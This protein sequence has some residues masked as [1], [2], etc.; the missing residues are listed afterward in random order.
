MMLLEDDDVMKKFII[1]KKGPANFPPRLTQ[2]LLRLSETV[3]GKLY[4]VGGLVRDGLTG[5]IS[6]DIDLAVP[7][8]AVNLAR[9][10]AHEL[11]ATFVLLDEDE[12]VARVVWQEFEIDLADFHDN[13]STINQD[14]S[15]RDFTINAL[16]VNLAHCLADQCELIDPCGGLADL[17]SGSIRVVAKDSF[18]ADPLRLLRAFRF[19][20]TLDFSLESKTLAA[21]SDMAELIT[22]PSPERI[23]Y[24]LEQIMLTERAAITFA[25][26]A[27]CG[28]LRHIFPELSQGKGMA[29]PASHHLDVFF[30]NMAALD[31][32]EKLQIAPDRFFPEKLTSRIISYLEK[33]Q[34]R[35]RL[36][37]AALFHDLGKPACH[38]IRRERITFY[39][40]DQVGADEFIKIAG[41]LR[42]SRADI[43]NI[44]LLIRLH[45]WP[46]HLNNARKKNGLTSRAC[47]RLFKAIGP[48]L[49]GLFLLTMADSLAGQGPGRP[50]DM[51]KEL[52]DLYSEIDRICR[53]QIKP[54]L[55]APRLVNGRDLIALG[56]QPGPI[57]KKILA[58]LEQAQV[59]G[60]I[61][62]RRDA[63][64]YLKKQNLI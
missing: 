34:T 26:M 52:A 18:A 63:L 59:D 32:M 7:A 35:V 22:R 17:E 3:A 46:F 38:A 49:P 5:G 28:L 20:A 29:Q 43:K 64:N 23:S 4:L 13:S 27:D 41:R 30:H 39:N 16:A 55:N 33:S 15:K 1:N 37:W 47:L 50:P 9:S 8:N 61:S 48:D 31:W 10:L 60:K 45:M 57:F 25:Q 19:A 42:W 2:A 54:A 6:H 11:G 36:K 56:L 21:I 53:Q 12:G 51:E 62:S 40:H 24:E 14:L 44:S 58:L